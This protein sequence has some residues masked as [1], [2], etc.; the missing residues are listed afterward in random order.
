MGQGGCYAGS[1]WLFEAG[2]WVPV[3]RGWNDVLVWWSLAAFKVRFI[4]FLK[5]RILIRLIVGILTIFAWR[6]FAKSTSHLILPPTFR[7][8]HLPS[9]SSAYQSI[10]STLTLFSPECRLDSG[11]ITLDGQN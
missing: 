8:Y 9:A 10:G 11:K 6:I 7:F 1:G 3:E 5:S 2:R 4:P